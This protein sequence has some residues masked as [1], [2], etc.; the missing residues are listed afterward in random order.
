VI[1]PLVNLHTIIRHALLFD[2]SPFRP[3]E[4][5]KTMS[6]GALKRACEA[7]YNAFRA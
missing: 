6:L 5:K 4:R 3:F 2:V 1:E 7:V